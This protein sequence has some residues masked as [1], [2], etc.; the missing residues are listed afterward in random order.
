[1]YTYIDAAA[2]KEK[3]VEIAQMGCCCDDEEFTPDNYAAGNIDDSYYNGVGD[4][5]IS[6]ARK[7]LKD[8]WGETHN[9]KTC[10]P[11]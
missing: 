8:F 5:E 3:L 6:F 4:G 2:I 7:L 10:Q 11:C 1:M 9:N